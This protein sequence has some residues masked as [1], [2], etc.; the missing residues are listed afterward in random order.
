MADITGSADK[1]WMACGLDP[2]DADESR[3]YIAYNLGVVRS[4]TAGDSW[5][6]P[7][8][9]PEFGLG[10]LP[11][12]GPNGELYIAYWDVDDGIKMLRSFDGGQTLQ[13]PIEIAQ[14]MDVWGIDGT[15]F[16]GEFRVASLTYLAVDPNNGTLYCVY[17]DTTNVSGG[18]RNVDLYF[19]KSTDQGDNWT[20]PVVINGDNDPPGDQFFPWLEV[21]DR[22]RIHLMFYD[23]R[24]TPGNDD[25]SPAI[26]EAYYSYSDDSG[27][28]WTELV[29]T[30]QP[31]SSADDGFGDFFIGDYLGMG[32]G[33]CYVYPCYLSTHEGVGNVY[34]RQVTDQLPYVATDFQ[35]I[36]GRLVS[37][38]ATDIAA[39]DDQRLVFRSFKP[40]PGL[41]R[42][43]RVVPRN[44]VRLE[45]FTAAPHANPCELRFQLEAQVEVENLTQRIQ[46]FDYQAN[47]FVEIDARPATIDDSV[48]EVILRENPE[49]FFMPKTSLIKAAVTWKNESGP[50]PNRWHIG[51]DQV[52][53]IDLSTNRQ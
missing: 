42:D 41:N 52:Q 5:N 21:D 8:S 19:C 30:N 29:M 28:S 47:Q 12:I 49:R 44:S 35:K 51:V 25:V 6:G 48:T 40:P 39:S 1:G 18:N 16:P 33:G 7:V 46:L 36:V 32:I 27:D 26:I 53:W 2:F 3:L 22:G 9:L 34:V 43:P 24:G 10:L 15:R 31:F 11:R 50:A 45:F 23:T 14:R 38:D 13:G 20:V 17:F 37:G 4:T